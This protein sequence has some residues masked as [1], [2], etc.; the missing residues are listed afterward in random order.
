MSEINVIKENLLNVN[1]SLIALTTGTEKEFLDI[2]AKLADYSE[3][4]NKILGVA[5]ST[6]DLI[7]GS[8]MKNVIQELGEILNRINRYLDYNSEELDEKINQFSK[9]LEISD[10][11]N[12]PLQAL[13]RKTMELRMLGVSTRIESAHINSE[14]SSFVTLSNEVNQLSNQIAGK[15]EMIENGLMDSSRIVN[16][17]YKE[18][19]EFKSKQASSAISIF[20]RINQCIEALVIK[21]DQSVNMVNS[22]RDDNQR[23]TDGVNG[24]VGSLQIHDISRQKLEHVTEAIDDLEPDAIDVQQEIDKEFIMQTADVCKLQI[25][26]L[27]NTRMEILDAFQS[28][29]SNGNNIASTTRQMASNTSKMMTTSDENSSAFCFDVESGIESVISSLRNNANIIHDLS[30]TTM[31]ISGLIKEMSVFIKD[32]KEIGTNITLI[33]LN[34]IINAEHLHKEGAALSVLADAIQQLSVNTK[35][36]IEKIADNLGTI[37]ELAKNLAYM[38]SFGDE[39]LEID[40]VV[41]EMSINLNTLLQKLNKMFTNSSSYLSQIESDGNS[42]FNDLDATMNSISVHHKLEASIIDAI[43][44]LNAV[45]DQVQRTVP[46]YDGQSR[47]INTDN[48]SSRYTMQSERSIHDAF[49][50]NTVQD[51][52]D[53]TES[54][55]D[56]GD[57]IELF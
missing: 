40:T 24:I 56:L 6:T 46:E 3:R 54:D 49:V 4:S 28:I 20:S 50:D 35:L 36:D 43:G 39:K 27:Y 33:A 15:L 21:H 18:V 7:A 26:Q 29:I 9:I 47:Q 11:N 52:A 41:D 16:K 44:L 53:F 34:A 8:D 51:I 31:Q 17:T 45:I 2:G 42:L 55:D 48:L 25:Q 13:E 22:I 12:S 32:I 57:N 19:S 37:T 1:K 30:Q 10:K 5:K 38:N 14:N 23:I